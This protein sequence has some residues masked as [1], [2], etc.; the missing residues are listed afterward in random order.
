MSTLG[1]SVLLSQGTPDYLPSGGNSW[2]ETRD[3]CEINGRSSFSS[4]TFDN[5]IGVA[6]AIDEEGEVWVIMADSASKY[7]KLV[8]EDQ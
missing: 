1:N 6:L 2:A 5:E 4:W 7:G 8:G 3:L